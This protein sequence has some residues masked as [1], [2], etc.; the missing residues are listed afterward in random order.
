[1]TTMRWCCDVYC[2]ARL[3]S[4]LFGN[5]TVPTAHSGNH[6]SSDGLSQEISA[7]IVRKTGIYSWCSAAYDPKCSKWARSFEFQ[8]WFCSKNLDQDKW[9]PCANI[10]R[11]V[12]RKRLNS[13]KTVS[14]SDE[15]CHLI[16]ARRFTGWSY[17]STCQHIG[18]TLQGSAS[19]GTAP[20]L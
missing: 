10:K 5:K 16:V 14:I 7:L 4:T 20:L 18:Q 6:R 12:D 19:N 11:A 17:T 3:K 8:R 1:M 15:R 13:L 2:D 9:S